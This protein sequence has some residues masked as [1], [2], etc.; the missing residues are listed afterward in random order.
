MLIV[1]TYMKL[2]VNKLE[3]W[4]KLCCA[5]LIMGLEESKFAAA[6]NFKTMNLKPY[7]HLMTIR[8][9][10]AMKV[11][12]KNHIQKRMNLD[13]IQFIAKRNSLKAPLMMK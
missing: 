8:N 3:N 9:S 7:H 6:W 11:F 4:K 13:F 2:S 12:L 10:Q 5:N 1:Q